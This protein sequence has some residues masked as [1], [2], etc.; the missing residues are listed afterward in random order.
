[1]AVKRN[2]GMGLDLLLTAGEGNTSPARDS[3]N[4]KSAASLMAR[5]IE[6]DEKGNIFEAYHLYRRVIDCQENPVLRGL[7]SMSALAAQA[8][9]N[10]AV[11]LCE[12]GKPESAQVFLTQALHLQPDNQVALENL[13]LIRMASGS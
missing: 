6:E 11:I 5:A 4:I 2:L 12:N 10:V 9:N 1:M 3:L 8:L 7:P 13:Q